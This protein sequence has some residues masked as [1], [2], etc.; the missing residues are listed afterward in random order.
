MD[1]PMQGRQLRLGDR[2][3]LAVRAVSHRQRCKLATTTQRRPSTNVTSQAA[4]FA[5][6]TDT[7]N[8]AGAVDEVRAS[9]HAGSR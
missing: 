7:H 3:E 6:G 5:D 4:L 1:P 2:D 8:A 9:A